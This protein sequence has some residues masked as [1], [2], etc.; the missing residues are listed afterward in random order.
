MDRRYIC[1]PGEA[2]RRVP[3]GLSNETVAAMSGGAVSY[4]SVVH[5]AR[6]QKGETVLVSGASGGLGS[7][8]CMV[9]KAVGAK[10]IALAGNEQKAEHMR[11]DMDVDL[12]LV[13]QD[14]WLDKVLEFTDGRGVEVFLDNTGMVNDAIR[15]LAYFGRIVI[16]GFAARKGIMEEVRMNKILLK[17][18]TVIG[19]RFGESG[20]R[21]PQMLED[22]WK[23]FLEM[24][25]SGRVKPILYGH[26][27][28]LDDMGRALSDLQ[29]RKVFGK[30][31]VQ[32][33]E[34]PISGK[35]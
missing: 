17:S 25:E 3:D 9:A 20:R 32:V 1:V 13:L 33:A 22:I 29:H 11:R 35:I 5:I 18:I 21:Y 16:V 15:S 23:G 34:V 4:A 12:V 14:G 26:Y 6:V 19:Y 30:I 24:L 31:V 2:I 28:S 7:T 10:V 27:R 8:C